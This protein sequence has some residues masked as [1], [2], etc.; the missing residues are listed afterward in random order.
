[1][2][3][4]APVRVAFAKLDLGARDGNAQEERVHALWNVA[5]SDTR[6]TPSSIQLADSFPPSL[7]SWCR[8]GPWRV[9]LC[10]RRSHDPARR[11]HELLTSHGDEAKE[12]KEA[13]DAGETKESEAR[14][15]PT[16]MPAPTW[17]LWCGDLDADDQRKQLVHGAARPAAPSAEFG[18]DTVAPVAPSARSRR[19]KKDDGTR[20]VAT[21]VRGSSHSTALLVALEFR[22]SG[23]SLRW[24][25]H[26]A[27]SV[28]NTRSNS[29]PRTLL[30]LAVQDAMRLL[31]VQAEPAAAVA[32]GGFAPW[33]LSTADVRGKCGAVVQAHTLGLLR[34]AREPQLVPGDI[35]NE[36]ELRFGQM[37]AGRFDTGVSRRFFRAVVQAL[38]LLTGSATPLAECWAVSCDVHWNAAGV[39]GQIQADELMECSTIERDSHT[40]VQVDGAATDADG[41]T[42][43]LQLAS[44][45]ERRVRKVNTLELGVPSGVHAKNRWQCASDGTRLFYET[46]K[47][48]GE[49]KRAPEAGESKLAAVGAVGAVGAAA[50]VGPGPILYR[51]AATERRSGACKQSASKAADVTFEL[52]I[53]GTRLLHE[54]GRPHTLV[55]TLLKAALQLITPPGASTS[56]LRLRAV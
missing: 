20:L 21:F 24:T 54:L 48:P 43:M 37:R 36:F 35:D 11:H 32:G 16:P 22:F 44:K 8:S 25:V 26:V 19:E 23:S 28:C 9:S 52:E 40:Y 46:D 34:V 13:K 50:A 10:K 45:I 12:A 47:P 29:A 5:L 42:F 3:K 18:C 31:L 39:R 41:S 33:H 53:E 49:A 1:M 38:H 17:G 7:P 56:D 4:A 14:P 30:E 55:A 2:A 27:A 51:I 15:E 6:W